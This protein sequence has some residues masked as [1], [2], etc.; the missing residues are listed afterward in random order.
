MAKLRGH[1]LVCLHFYEGE[2]YDRPFIDSLENV[3][4]EIETVGVEV[5]AGA[6]DVCGPC[7]HRTGTACTMS[8]TADREIR[9]MDARAL[10]LLDLPVGHKTGWDV[11][12]DAVAAVFPA[13]Y[14]SYCFAC[15][16]RRA[17]E[18]KDFFRQLTA[19]RAKE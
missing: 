8:A 11:L 2:G 7:P 15:N 19:G 12:R 4:E 10:A 9:E 16:W 14:E 1:H 3:I 6:D 17:C 5:A 13:W 18:K